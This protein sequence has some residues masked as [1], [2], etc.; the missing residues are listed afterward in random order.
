MTPAEW[1][2]ISHLAIVWI[3]LAGTLAGTSVTAAGAFL[4]GLR[5]RRTT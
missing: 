5:H 2:A 4:I 3:F 1:A